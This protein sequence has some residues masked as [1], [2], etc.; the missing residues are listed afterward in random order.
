MGSEVASR[1]SWSWLLVFGLISAPAI[2][3]RL[4]GT[5]LDP[6]VAVLLFGIGIVGGAF[7]IS[8]AAEAAQVD[9]SASFAIAV[10]ALIAVL[11]EAVIESVLAWDAG[12]SYTRGMTVATDEMHR[13]AAI[14]TGSNR[15]LIGLGWS[16]V[17]LIYWVRRRR[18]LDLRG[19][20]GLEISILGLATMA[21][22]FIF[23]MSEVH[24][25]LSFV[26]IG[27]YV[28]YLWIT[29]TKKAEEP[30]L[31]GVSAM[32]GSLPKTQRRATV[33]LLFVY[34]AAVIFAAA[35]PFVHALVE[36]GDELGI[37]EFILIQWIAPLA[38]ES[39]EI[40]VAL[41]FSLRANPVAG[42]TT[43]ISAQVNQLTLLVGTMVVL[44]SVAAGEAFSFP[45]DD[46]QS[47]EFLLM[48]VVSGFA[49]ILI[50]PRLLGWR[51]GAVLLGLFIVHLFF[52]DKEARLIFAYIYAA[53][54]TGLLITYAVK[55]LRGRGAE[56]IGGR[57]EQVVESP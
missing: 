45:L 52:T 37:D 40:I 7:I 18:T 34:A 20:G 3:L 15:L 5:H 30:E 53:L 33:I 54:A 42:L 29:S 11:P 47:V 41:L 28:F 13:V 19:N 49:I 10:L 55:L 44:F 22:L 43:L 36:T 8:W 27:V 35:E 2:V 51:T 4:A 16:L 26:L 48:T 56:I 38:S 23:F 32:I 46:R 6:V 1:R 17:I 57:T 12:N 31:M 21:G 25:I 9:V 14:V 50:A 39:P 24:L